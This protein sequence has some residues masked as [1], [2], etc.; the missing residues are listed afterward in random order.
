MTTTWHRASRRAIRLDRVSTMTSEAPPAPGDIR[1]P[2]LSALLL[3]AAPSDL[4]DNS[5]QVGGTF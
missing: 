3:G 2:R 5:L 1:A 4:A